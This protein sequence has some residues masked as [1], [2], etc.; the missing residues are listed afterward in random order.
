MMDATPWHRFGIIQPENNASDDREG[1]LIHFEANSV[2][3]QMDKGVE[4]EINR[5]VQIY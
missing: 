1:V 2:V 3:L 5:A 4:Q